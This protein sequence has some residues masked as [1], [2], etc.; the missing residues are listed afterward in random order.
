MRVRG[1]LQ[2][3]KTM[4]IYTNWLVLRRTILTLKIWTLLGL[5]CC[6]HSICSC[7]FSLFLLHV[8]QR[9][10]CRM[11]KC[12]ATCLQICAYTSSG[13]SKLPC[14]LHKLAMKLCSLLWWSLWSTVIHI[15]IF[16]LQPKLYKVRYNL[17]HRKWDKWLK[18]IYMLLCGNC[19]ACGKLSLLVNSSE[20]GLYKKHKMH[21]KF[22][23][24]ITGHHLILRDT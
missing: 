23:P 21:L 24:L 20:T 17:F 12:N 13:R 4:H 10:S 22:Q 1:L 7:I 5:Q 18:E 14:I 9:E 11:N 15:Y 8:L 16:I 3:K 6:P 19:F 2:N